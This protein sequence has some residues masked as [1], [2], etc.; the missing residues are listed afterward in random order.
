MKSDNLCRIIAICACLGATSGA[1]SDHPEELLR[2]V[3]PIGM[4][5]GSLVVLERSEPKTLNPVSA[6]DAPSRDVIRRMMA[7]LVSIN[8]RTFETEPSL[9][10]TWTASKDGREFVLQLR[11]GLRFSDGHPMDADDV[12]FTFQVYL[13]ESIAFAAARSV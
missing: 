13:D 4:S 7:D 11:R 10:K 1:A 2:T 9:A 6:L 12:V 8:R 5:G 3:A